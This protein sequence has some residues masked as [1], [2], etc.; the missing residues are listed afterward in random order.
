MYEAASG[1]RN[2]RYQSWNWQHVNRACGTFSSF[3]RNQSPSRTENTTS[4]SVAFS[5]DPDNLFG[6][7]SV[8]RDN[9]SQFQ[10]HNAGGPVEFRR[11][12]S[13]TLFDSLATKTSYAEVQDRIRNLCI[14]GLELANEF[15]C[16]VVMT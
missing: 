8:V 10:L 15:F 3:Q 11:S 4:G 13:A 12:D 5:Q 16:A 2:G 7:P 14:H 9:N 6:D 1:K